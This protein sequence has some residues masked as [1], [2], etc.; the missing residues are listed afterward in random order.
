MRRTNGVVGT[1]GGLAALLCA[2]NAQAGGPCKAGSSDPCITATGRVVYTD[3][4]T[5]D[6]TPLPNVRVRLMDHNCCGNADEMAQGFTNDDGTFQLQ[7]SAGSRPDPYMQFVTQRDGYV[8]VKSWSGA[9]YRFDTEVH[10]DARGTIDFGTREMLHGFTSLDPGKTAAAEGSVIGNLY[11][12]AGRTY[13]N[14]KDLTGDP[15]VPSYG[16]N[17]GVLYPSIINGGTVGGTATPFTT[18]NTI[19]WVVEDDNRPDVIFHEFGHR[20]REAADGDGGHFLGDM[21]RFHYAQNHNMRTTI[22]NPGFAFNEGWAEYHK[23]LLADGARRELENWTELPGGDNLEGNVAAKLLRLADRCG[24]FPALWPIL[25]SHPSQPITGAGGIH[26]WAEFFATF[27]QAHPECGYDGTMT[28]PMAT[29]LEEP[30]VAVSSNGGT[31]ELISTTGH[32]S[33]NISDNGGKNWP[34]R[35][36]SLGSGQFTSAPATAMSRDGTHRVVFGR[37]SSSSN[38]AYFGASSSDGGYNWTGWTQVPV[39]V[40]FKSAP[41]VAMSA[42]GKQVF[43]FGRGGDDCMWYADS[44]NGGSSWPHGWRK[45]TV[46][47]PGADP[48]FTSGAAAVVSP[49]GKQVHVFAR[50]KD[51]RIWRAYSSNGA[52]SWDIAFVPINQGTFNSGPAAVLSSQDGNQLHVIARGKDNR[53]YRAFSGNASGGNPTWSLDW[54]PIGTGLFTSAP[55]AVL[56]RFGHHLL[57]FGRGTDGKTIFQAS[58][59]DGGASWPSGWVPVDMNPPST[60]LPRVLAGGA[61]DFL[62]YADTRAASL[63]FRQSSMAQDLARTSTDTRPALDRLFAVASPG[64]KAWEATARQAFRMHL[65]PIGQRSVADKTYEHDADVAR[66]AYVQAAGSALLQHLEAYARALKDERSRATNAALQ[67]YLDEEIARTAAHVATVQRALANRGGVQKVPDELIPSTFDGTTV[68]I[69]A[70][71][72]VVP[73]RRREVRR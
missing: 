70:T 55:A 49:D 41:A 29:S 10:Y 64:A 4:V 24:G 52:Q 45:V 63:A 32:Y 56:D 6:V 43:L 18:D 21:I 17:V 28:P 12:Y 8:D 69:P 60:V 33:Q 23:T 14:F 15:H 3:A 16:G 57:V 11:A 72:H 31:F 50:G 58:S 25:K 71:V 26:S 22:A 44:P 1:A 9:S 19:H 51:D 48:S 27:K 53:F 54:T 62:K 67:R 59:Q 65:L 34:P 5:H 39:G 47:G 46:P 38:S 30:P 35:G 13:D 2:A 73:A 42:D 36:W 20:I 61:A 66:G 7:G 37:G 40:S 68:Q